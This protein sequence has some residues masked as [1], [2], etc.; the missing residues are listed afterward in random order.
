MIV[1]GLCFLT[2]GTDIY[3]QIPKLRET[4]EIVLELRATCSQEVN[5]LLFE[6][7]GAAT[8]NSPALEEEDLLS[9]IKSVAVKEIHRE[10]HRINFGKHTQSSGESITHF[11]ARLKAQASL[12]Q[13]NVSCSCQL[14][15]SFAEEMVSQQLVAGLHNKDHQARL[16]GEANQL[17]TLKKKIDRLVSLETAAE[18]TFKMHRSTSSS[19]AAAATS[20]YR[21]IKKDQY[22]PKPKG[23][24]A[25]NKFGTRFKCRGCGQ[26]NHGQGKTKSRADC[27]ANTKKC[28]GCGIIGHFQA[29]CRKSRARATQQ[30]WNEDGTE[31]ENEQDENELSQSSSSFIFATANEN[32]QEYMGFQM[33]PNVDP[34]E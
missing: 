19:E 14:K 10:V 11:A 13:F 26:E 4:Q 20:Q 1:I 5:K 30:T 25:F 9:H 12:C 28:L 6:Y 21:R 24:E 32:D 16:L 8:L 2:S 29:V 15:V 17:D 3:K 33:D 31:D 23:K 27:P 34:P 7:V 22:V 18:A